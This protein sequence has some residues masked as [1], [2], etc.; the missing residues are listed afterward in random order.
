MWQLRHDNLSVQNGTITTFNEAAKARGHSPHGDTVN[1]TAVTAL[2]TSTPTQF[3]EESGPLQTPYAHNAPILNSQI[4]VALRWGRLSRM[5]A[6]EENKKS[7]P[8]YPR[9]SQKSSTY[10]SKNILLCFSTKED[11][12][13]S[14]SRNRGSSTANTLEQESEILAAIIGRAVRVGHVLSR[15]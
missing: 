14:T 4:R 1:S 15:E 3:G 13:V 2:V 6:R 8:D 9:D 7:P 5:G 12:L 10:Y 11:Y